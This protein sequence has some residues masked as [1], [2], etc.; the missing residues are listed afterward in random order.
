VP[1]D[2][3]VLLIWDEVQTAFGR[4]GRMFA[5]D[6]YGVAPDILT[7][8]KAIAWGFPLAG[9]LHRA[10]LEGM[11][12]GDHGFTFAHFPVAMAAAVV[13]LRVLQE[14]ELLSGRRTSRR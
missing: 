3:D 8:G 14:E 13:T 5:S 6:L 1:P 10:D 4:V 7:F 12:P 9:T 2:Y 11:E